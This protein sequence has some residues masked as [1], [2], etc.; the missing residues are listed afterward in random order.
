MHGYAR[1]FF[2]RL[3]SPYNT[4]AGFGYSMPTWVN[5]TT[6]MNSPVRHYM[7]CSTNSLSGVIS[8]HE[9]YH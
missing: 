6:S 2:F 1:P 5:G 8:S 7:T 3:K 9:V 4:I